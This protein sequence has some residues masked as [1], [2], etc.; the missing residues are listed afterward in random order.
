MFGWLYSFVY[1]LVEAWARLLPRERS[2]LLRA[3]WALSLA[4]LASGG[5]DDDFAE[6][7]YQLILQQPALL[8]QLE[9]RVTGTGWRAQRKRLLLS[10]LRQAH[11]SGARSTFG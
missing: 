5:Q 1:W 6:E 7:L 11:A 9:Q 4:T 10:C 3:R 8:D 2:L